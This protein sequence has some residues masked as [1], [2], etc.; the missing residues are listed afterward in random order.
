[1]QAVCPYFRTPL[2]Y[3]EQI[4]EAH[5]LGKI[6][7]VYTVNEAEDMRLLIEAGIDGM[8]SD[9]PSLLLEVMREM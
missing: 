7:F 5:R 2:T 6:V 9:R 8:V 4:A 3:P 1:V